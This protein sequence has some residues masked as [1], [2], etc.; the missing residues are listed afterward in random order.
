MEG[1]N[2]SNYKIDLLDSDDSSLDVDQHYRG[3]ATLNRVDLNALLKSIVEQDGTGHPQESS[4]FKNILEKMGK[5]TD[6]TVDWLAE[7]FDGISLPA[8]W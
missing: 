1:L 3:T 5:G 2:L 6:Q 4:Y 8:P 7:L